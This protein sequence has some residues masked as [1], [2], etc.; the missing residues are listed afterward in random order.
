MKIRKKLF[1]LVGIPLISLMFI[2]IVGLVNLTTIK[3]IVNNITQLQ[4]DRATMIDA[5][6]DA[7]QALIDIKDIQFELNKDKV[8]QLTESINENLQQTW[9]RMSG[10]AEGFSQ[11]M[12][13]QYQVFSQEYQQWYDLNES[14]L[15]LSLTTVEKNREIQE[16]EGSAIA[17]FD[18]MRNQINLMGELIDGELNKTLSFNRRRALE[19]ALSLVLNADRDAYQ[20]YVAQLLILSVDSEDQLA[21][22]D[23]SSKE[24]LGQTRERVNQAVEIMGGEA[25]EMLE[26]FNQEFNNWEELSRRVVELSSR[27]FQDNFS[28]QQKLT[29]SI[30][31]FE[32]M[33]G[34]INDL[35]EMQKQRVLLE[36][37]RAGTI[38]SNTIMQFFIISIVFFVGSLVFAY[39][40]T[41]RITIPLLKGVSITKMVA[42]GDLRNTMDIQQNDEIGVLAGAVN[43]MIDGLNNVIGEIR[44]SSERVGSGS[45]QINTT[46]QQISSGA[47][48]QAASTEEISSSMEQLAANIQQNMENSQRADKI[49]VEL[50]MDAAKGA[51]TVNKTVDA[52]RVIAEKIGVIE[53]ISRNTNMLALNAAIEAA[54]AGEA[55]KGFAVVAAEVRKLAETSGKAAS[56]ITGIASTSVEEAEKA[57]EIIN[58]LIP[59]ITETAD[60]VKEITLASQEQSHGASQI[61][62][63]IQQLDQVIQRNASASEE[64]AAMAEELNIQSQNLENSIDYF[65]IKESSLESE[66]AVP[67]TDQPLLE[68]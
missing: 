11:E 61:N 12:D 4:N 49:S 67:V 60:I 57:G 34:A 51:K 43:S 54:R 1:L 20:A 52:M 36:E 25:N 6:R 68:Q 13:S 55:G 38:I 37:Q 30:T 59:K 65:K 27:S 15:E 29:Q 35:G 17:S 64:M 62:S 19:K 31:H 7:Y 21:D 47:N 8:L 22:L 26:I 18:L 14:I 41:N 48:E 5:D 24:N 33:R 66:K 9:D 63:S 42:D 39:F 44:E 23:S 58:N 45:Q 50:A 53:N 40:M 3:T 28:L 10:P 2:L 16:K 46:S 32:I 56:E